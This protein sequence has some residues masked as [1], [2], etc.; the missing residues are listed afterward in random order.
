[1]RGQSESHVELSSGAPSNAAARKTKAL[2]NE[3]ISGGASFARVSGLTATSIVVADMVGVGVFTSLGFQVKD[4]TSGFSLLALWIIGGIVAMC[5]A[6]SYAELA[7]MFPRSSGEYNFLR[8]IYHPAFGFV[9]GFLSA[10]VG[11]AAPV[12]LAAMAFS[13]YFRSVIPDAPLPWPGLVVVWLISLVHLSG[14]RQGSA[15][16]NVWTAIKLVLIVAFLVSGLVLGGRQPISFAPSAVDLTF[17][18]SAPFAISLVFVMYSYSGW[19]AATYI[20]GEIEEPNRNLPLALFLGTAIVIVAYVGLNAVFLSVTPMQ[21]LAGQLDVAMIA[22]T[23]MFGALGGRIVGMLICIGLV[24]S[25]SAMMWIGPRVTMT[26]GEDMPLLRIFSRKSAKGV[27]AAA[28][29]FQLLV[30]TLLLLSGSFEKVLDFIQF[31]LTFCSFFTVLGVIT[32]RITRPKL[33]RPYRAWGYPVTPLVFLA[34]MLW[35]MY[36]LVVNRPVQSLA[37][38]GMMLSG[39]AIYGASL[40]LSK[41]MPSDTPQATV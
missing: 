5:G 33:P 29:I 13:V 34:V 3:P 18:T 21:E 15:F 2:M 11:F 27:P 9:A 10:T 41:A 37:G 36:Y 4:I 35:M 1:V 30:S 25:I 40:L 17:I 23:H 12:A 16:Q 39:L 28:I 8:R 32:L 22:G 7:L 31:S 24:S 19:N 20:I 38:F 14:I 26:M 6:I